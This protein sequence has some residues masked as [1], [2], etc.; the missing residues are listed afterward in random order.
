MGIGM[1]LR[2]K[3]KDGSIFP[4]EVSLN[5]FTIGQGRFVMGLVT[6]IT[7]RHQAETGLLR[8]R[9][10][11]EDR[12]EQ[13]TEQLRAAEANVRK[14]LETERELHALKPLRGHGKP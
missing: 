4:V 12:V 14:A 2:G 13:R 7:M 8:S 11:L 6:D 3:R 9:Q 1:D 5:H 10:E